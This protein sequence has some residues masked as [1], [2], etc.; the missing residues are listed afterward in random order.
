MKNRGFLKNFKPKKH[1][2]GMTLLDT[3]VTVS[4]VGSVSAV[5]LPK[6]NGLPS[7]ARI[8]V[9]AQMAGAVRSA[10]HLV[11][12]KCA[13]QATCDLHSGVGSVDLAGDAVSLLNGYPLAGSPEGIANAV[14]YVGFTAQHAP[15]QTWFGKDGAPEPEACGVRYEAATAAGQSPHVIVITSGC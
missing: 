7:E 3:L 15:D 1:I 9:V 6:L 5:A 11:H 2:R 4:V 8:A 10:S 12:M 14:E 13:V